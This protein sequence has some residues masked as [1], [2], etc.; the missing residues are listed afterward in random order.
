LAH[1]SDQPVRRA[2]AIE[3]TA[4]LED[5]RGTLKALSTVGYVNEGMAIYFLCGPLS[6]KA[7]N[8]ARD[9][10]ISLTIDHDTTDPMEITGLSMAAHAQ[11]VTDRAEA[12]KAMVL[13][14]KR[15]PNMRCFPW[16]NRKRS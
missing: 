15:Y 16:R 12:A 14:G 4:R 7:Q 8:I 9:N 1:D 13:L 10:R 6:Q 3:D 5:R 2:I 11:P